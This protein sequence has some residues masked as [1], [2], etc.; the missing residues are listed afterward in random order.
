MFG[1]PKKTF[2]TYS[3]YKGNNWNVAFS[4]RPVLPVYSSKRFVHKEPLFRDVY[5]WIDNNNSFAFQILGMLILTAALFLSFSSVASADSS[6]SDAKGFV[7]LTNN[8]RAA[9][10]D[11][12]TSG[13]VK[14]QE[15]VPEVPAGS[16][17][18]PTVTAPVVPQFTTYTVKSGESLYFI[19]NK[20]TVDCERVKDL[21][22]LKYPYTLSVGQDIRIPT[23]TP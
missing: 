11:P 14:P 10:S 3:G 9:I 5:D 16:E 18:N 23:V 13:K 8:F 15:I 20:L 2:G 12:E 22:E 1:L 4:K 21:N 19:C 7:Y 6:V 17:T